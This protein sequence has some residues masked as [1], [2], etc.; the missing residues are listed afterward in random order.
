LNQIEKEQLEKDGVLACLMGAGYS[1][2]LYECEWK[3]CFEK[4]SGNSTG[5]TFI[6]F[7]FFL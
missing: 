2:V 4:T 3:E 7:L 1:N 5:A 6:G